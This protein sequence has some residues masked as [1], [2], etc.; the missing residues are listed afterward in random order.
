MLPA[1]RLGSYRRNRGSARPSSRRRG[2]R[3]ECGSGVV[4]GSMHH[5]ISTL[6]VTGTLVTRVRT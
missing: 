6:L 1:L 2:D 4:I 5:A 3:V